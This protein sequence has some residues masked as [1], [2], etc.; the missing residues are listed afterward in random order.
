MKNPAYIFFSRTGRI[1]PAS[2]T[3]HLP[4]RRHQQHGPRPHLPARHR[5]GRGLAE[6]RWHHPL[7]VG[8]GRHHPA[9][10]RLHFRHRNVRELGFNHQSFQGV[11]GIR[12]PA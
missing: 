8:Q 12:L 9:A 2:W 1:D 10:R 3:V 7:Y 4:R 11:N 5:P 6:A